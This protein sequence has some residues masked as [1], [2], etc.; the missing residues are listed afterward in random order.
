VYKRQRQEALFVAA[1]KKLQEEGF[2]EWAQDPLGEHCARIGRAL[3]D[4]AQPLPADDPQLPVMTAAQTVSA[5]PRL[6]DGFASAPLYEG[7]PA[8]TGAL[9]RN[10]ELA[11][12]GPLAARIM[13]RVRD[14]TTPGRLGWTSAAAVAPGVGRAAVETARG[15]LLHEIALDGDCVSA[16][17]IVAPTEWNFHPAGALKSLLERMP[18]GDSEELKGFAERAVLAF[19]PCVRCDIA[20]ETS[21]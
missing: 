17:V 16:Y 11:P 1:R 8:C 5:W 21:S 9:A 12:L 13:A 15:L 14:L 10:P 6:D 19:D 20:M 18:A 3:A 2:A 7:T 4:G